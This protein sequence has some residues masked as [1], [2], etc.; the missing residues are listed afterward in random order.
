MKHSSIFL[1]V[2]S[3]V[4]MFALAGCHR[5]YKVVHA[6]PTVDTLAHVKAEAPEED[7]W[8][9]GPLLDIPDAPEE[10]DFTDVSSKTRKE[11]DDYIHGR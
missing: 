8:D 9:E 10:E 7:D 4:I 11:F 6:R 3:F 1:L 5:N 2:V